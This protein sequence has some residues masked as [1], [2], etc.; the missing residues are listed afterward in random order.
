MSS[1]PKI[2]AKHNRGLLLDVVV[3]ILN[4]FLMRWLTGWLAGGE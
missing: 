3:F 4:I 1:P 2:F